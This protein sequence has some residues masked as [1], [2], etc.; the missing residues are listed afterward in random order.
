MT[1]QGRATATTYIS[2][3]AKL[4]KAEVE[5]IVRRARVE[6]LVGPVQY[7]LML[8]P[9]LPQDHVKRARLDPV[10]WDLTVRCIDLDNASKVMG[11]SLNGLVWSDDSLIRKYASE[12]MVPD[13]EARAVIRVRQYVRDDPRG[14]MF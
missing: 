3:D 12:I 10:W 14:R 9:Q 5:Q 1:V 7:E 2:G 6:M 11:D 8:Y 4:Y 13:G